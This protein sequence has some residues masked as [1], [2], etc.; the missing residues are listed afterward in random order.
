MFNTIFNRGSLPYME[1]VLHFTRARHTAI[2]S[3]LANVETPTYKVL[4]APVEE[5]EKALD[6]AVR[7]QNQRHVPV[8]QMVASNN[9]RPRPE[10]GL[11][12]AY[13]L[14]EGGILKHDENNVDIDR[15]NVKLVRNAQLHN[16]MAALIKFQ[17]D[18]LRTAIRGRTS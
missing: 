18:M 15:E 5:F 16:K 6:E 13:Q 9:V 1:Q 14:G 12:V 17:F 10:G 11:D 7:R 8:F 2:A 3:N 4:D